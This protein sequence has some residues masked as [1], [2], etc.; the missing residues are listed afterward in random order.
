MHALYT[1]ESKFFGCFFLIFLSRVKKKNHLF[2]KFFL[3]SCRCTITSRPKNHCPFEIFFIQESFS[4]LKKLQ[5]KVKSMSMS[6]KMDLFLRFS[7]FV[8]MTLKFVPNLL[9]IK[10]VLQL[11][12]KTET[13]YLFQNK[14]REIYQLYNLFSL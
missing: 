13:L 9:S 5:K 11:N 8:R 7:S 4:H 2:Q 12:V 14:I 3:G 6:I 1:S 10:I